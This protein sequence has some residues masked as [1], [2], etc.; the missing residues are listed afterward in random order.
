MLFGFINRFGAHGFVIVNFHPAGL[1]APALIYPIP[2]G[3]AMSV[4]FVFVG[5]DE[6]D[7][8]ACRMIHRDMHGV[9]PRDVRLVMYS[10]VYFY[11]QNVIFCGLSEP[12][13]CSTN[14]SANDITAASAKLGLSIPLF[15][16][17][18]LRS[19]RIRP[20]LS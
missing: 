20:A 18:F 19:T 3:N 12:L 1:I 15:N 11:G 5:V 7:R 16:I 10:F 4:A 6:L 9:D 13:G 2:I 17:S 14:C 8:K